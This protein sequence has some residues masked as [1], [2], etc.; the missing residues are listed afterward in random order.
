LKID[1]LTI[2]AGKFEWFYRE[3]LPRNESDQPPV[4][5]LHGI[6]SQSY[7]WRGVMTALADQGFRAIAPDWLGF[8]RSQK[9]DAR[10][11]AYTP[12]AYIAA[13]GEWVQALE[14]SQFSLV[15]QGF[16]G[17]VGLQYALRYPDQIHRLALCN[18]P[19]SSQARLPWKIQ[20][21][22]IPLIGDMLSQD[23]LLLDRTLEAAGPYQVDAEALDV[24]RRPWLKSSSAGRSLMTSVRNL[25]LKQAMAELDRNFPT[26][27]KPTL[28]I[29]GVADPWLPL[30]QAEA[31]I[32]TLQA[33][34]LSKL[35]GVGH[36]AQED[37]P[38][39]VSEVLI[40]FLRRQHA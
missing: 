30:E 31:L 3:A 4:I 39:K 29:W 21:F 2:Q 16:L 23:P 11:F 24:Y 33:G 18:T 22:G 19:V 7:S 6:P 35:E 1:L 15:V 17:S 25:Q 36:Y 10:D 8:G 40:P 34:E 37:W 13:L 38:E 20:Q 28:M 12:D 9:P 27:E 32:K 5:L 14:L 26:W